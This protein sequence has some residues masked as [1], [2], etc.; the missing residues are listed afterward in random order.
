MN[1][2]YLYILVKGIQICRNTKLHK[3]VIGL[4]HSFLFYTILVII[5]TYIKLLSLS[6]I[7]NISLFISNQVYTS[8]LNITIYMNYSI[9]IN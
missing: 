9:Y 3:I 8:L 6:I 1:S 2:N 4:S 5:F 7:N